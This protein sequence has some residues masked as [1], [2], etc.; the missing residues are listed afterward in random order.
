MWK[1]GFEEEAHTNREIDDHRESADGVLSPRLD[2][3]RGVNVITVTPTESF[4]S[5]PTRFV[6][7]FVSSFSNAFMVPPHSRVLVRR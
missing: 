1:S 5:P 6:I 4:G 2:Q 7:H 3:N